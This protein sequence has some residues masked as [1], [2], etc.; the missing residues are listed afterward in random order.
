[1]KTLVIILAQ[2]RAHELT[3]ES[4]ERHL[5]NPLKADL[6]VC[7]SVDKNYDYTNKFYTNAKY[8]FLLHE[9]EDFGPLFEYAYEKS[10][11]YIENPIYWRDY[12]RIKDQFMGGVKDPSNEHPGSAGI[13]IFFRWFLQKSLIENNLLEH[14][15]RFV[16]TRSDF[17]YTMD[18]APLEFL[19]EKCIW[20]PDCADWGGY[21]DRH[22]VLSKHNI[23]SYLNIFESLIDPRKNYYKKMK[24]YK[25]WNLERLIKF[26]LD[27]GPIVVKRFPYVM[28]AVR[29][30][31]G[32]TRWSK[33]TFNEKLGYYI[34]YGDEFKR[35]HEY[36]SKF[37]ESKQE[38]YIF[39][40]NIL[41]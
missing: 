23:F 11:K 3:Y 22:V 4:F 19:D 39:Y 17:I 24:K 33:G 14:Y 31:G 40:K 38:I 28:Y 2:T 15:D 21:T 35:S 36:K 30:K 1:M 10:I 34:K 13:L 8:K 32:S 12:L 37:M 9:P 7:I 29:E 16:I 5:L 18:H 6:C 41:S 27:N 25:H 20:I 26:H